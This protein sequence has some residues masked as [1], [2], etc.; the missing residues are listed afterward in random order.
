MNRHSRKLA[1][2]ELIHG[3]NTEFLL[4]KSQISQKGNSWDSGSFSFALSAFNGHMKD[5]FCGIH[6]GIMQEMESFQ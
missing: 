6:G 4:S 1:S 3:A 5:W 2:S